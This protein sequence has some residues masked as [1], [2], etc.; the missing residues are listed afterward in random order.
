MTGS[1]PKR[2]RGRPATSSSN[3][4]VVPIRRTEID[5]RKLGRA[6]LA[7]A[8]HADTSKTLSSEESSDE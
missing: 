8:L 4:R 5:A 7:L 3:F 2:Q 1:T 6:F